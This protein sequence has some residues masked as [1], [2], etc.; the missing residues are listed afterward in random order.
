MR[1]HVIFLSELMASIPILAAICARSDRDEYYRRSRQVHGMRWPPS[2]VRR[3]EI[4]ATTLIVRTWD[5]AGLALIA[6]SSA[7]WR[8][9]W[10]WT[11]QRLPGPVAALRGIRGILPYALEHPTKTFGALALEA[12]VPPLTTSASSSTSMSNSSSSMPG[13]VAPPG[14]VRP[15]NRS[16][17]SSRATAGRS[18]RPLRLS[19]VPSPARRAGAGC[20]P[21]RRIGASAAHRRPRIPAAK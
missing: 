11:R 9:S 12:L 16:P 18:R 4:S 15:S 1:R 8:C 13:T 6:R 17:P 20:G 14:A 19:P 21:R 7:R 5:L 2:G 10:P 3:F